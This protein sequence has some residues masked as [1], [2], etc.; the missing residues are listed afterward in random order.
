VTRRSIVI[1][2]VLAV[3]VAAFGYANDWICRLP[4]VASDLM[5][6]SVYGALV[7]GLVAINPVLTALKVRRLRGPEWAVICALVLVSCTIPGPGLLWQFHNALVMPH[8]FARITPG[9]QASEQ[10]KPL[11]EHV[12]KAMLVDVK[13]A[14]EG[15]VVNGFLQGLGHGAEMPS[16]ADVPWS[17]WLRPYLFYVPLI[18]LGTLAT[19]CLT[20]IL[21]VQWSRHEH[22]PFPMAEFAGALLGGSPDAPFTELSRRRPFWIG[23]G[24]AFGILLMNGSY[25][26]WP[27]YAFAVPQHVNLRPLGTLMP[28][29]SNVP[30]GRDLL[31]PRFFFAIIGLAFLI[32]AEVALSVGIS[33]V[34]YVV[35]FGIMAG[36]GVQVNNEYMAG[37]I[38]GFQLFG[39]Y[40]GAALFV[41]YTGRHFYWS[42][43]KAAFGRG[44]PPP[45]AAFTVNACRLFLAATFAMVML[46]RVAAGLDLLVA[47]CVVFLFGLLFVIVTRINA[48]TGLLF[49]QP[50]W[51]P[52]GI[53]LAFFGAHALG[54]TCIIVVGIL[55][56][57]L[58]ID[59]RVCLMPLVSN[60]LRLAE[61]QDLKLPRLG[62][63]L[64]GGFTLCLVVA[65]PVTLYLQYTVGGGVLYGWANSA[66]RMPFDLLG[67]ELHRLAAM[68]TLETAGTATGLFGLERLTQAVPTP[69]FLWAA[70][71]GLVLV[72]ACSAARLRWSKWPIHPVMFLIWGTLVSRWFAGS[73]LL[74]WFI[75]WLVLHY[76]SQRIY[77]EARRFFIG[78]IAGEMLAGLFWMLV[79]GV[80]YLI[81][82]VPPPLFR[83]HL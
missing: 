81:T 59:P 38:L 29:L 5:P 57:V 39:A 26:W 17:A 46:L 6:V 33:L 75:K 23:F 56:V 15:E 77:R 8:H 18:I 47:S 69:T 14:H 43:V 82:Q 35:T 78:M 72:F 27:Q 1:G 52:V 36:L 42:V 16:V 20:L 67:R 2:L 40:V 44:D 51:Q 64:V 34:V 10:R 74:G 58:T 30:G 55:C 71:A 12:P 28:W 48:E 79:G 68:G 54:P 7:L 83:V 70:G 45:D 76:G 49:V 60:G 53:L 19:V 50:T 22:L 37:G 11:L 13:E 63:W 9:W 73:F 32:K 24:V 65:L 62:G 4:Y 25:A 66:T 80:Y 31:F 21:H 61:T 41:A 3:F